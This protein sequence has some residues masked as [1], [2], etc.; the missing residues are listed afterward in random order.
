MDLSVEQLQ[1]VMHAI[2]YYQYHHVSINNPRYEE[3][4]N[5][6]KL[7]AKE[8]HNDLLASFSHPPQNISIC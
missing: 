4:S 1:D 3:Y 7:L 5:I 2:R 6:L 8:K